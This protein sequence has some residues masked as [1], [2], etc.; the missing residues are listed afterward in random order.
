MDAKIEMNE[1]VIIKMI[2][3]LRGIRWNMKVKDKFLKIVKR[4]LTGTT[5]LPPLA[6]PTIRCILPEYMDHRVSMRCVCN[7]QWY[8]C[9]QVE[10]G[11]FK[12]ICQGGGLNLFWHY[13]GL[14]A[15]IIRCMFYKSYCMNSSPN[16]SGLEVG[17][18]Y[19]L[20]SWM[21]ERLN[22]EHNNEQW[23]C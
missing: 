10:A 9:A 2:I 21:Q 20:D 4:Y 14:S 11:A 12:G 5:P 15:T 17:I 3:H 18:L 16:R 19:S 23:T 1:Q 13:R 8:C 6:L 22:L 7:V